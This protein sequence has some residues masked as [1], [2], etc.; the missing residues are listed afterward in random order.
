MPTIDFRYCIW[1]YDQENRMSRLC[2]G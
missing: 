1:V 2:Q